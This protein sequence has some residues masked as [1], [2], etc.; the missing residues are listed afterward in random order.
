MRPGTTI[1]LLGAALVLV[2]GTVSASATPVTVSFFEVKGSNGYRVEVA[3][4][5]LGA[6]P[7]ETS[8]SVS[9]QGLSANYVTAGKPGRGFQADFGDLGHL[10]LAF[11]RRKRAVERP[12]KGCT[13]VSETGSFRGSFSFT[14]EGDYTSVDRSSVN[15]IV[16]DLPNG[17][18]GLPD[19]R[20]EL[21]S[22]PGLRTSSLG[23]KAR[24]PHGTVNFAASVTEG[25]AA[26]N[27]RP[28][29]TAS[30]HER[31]ETLTITRSALTSGIPESLS[32]GDGTR[33]STATVSP[34][35]PFTGSATYSRPNGAA[36]RWAGTLSV[37]LLGREPVALA[38][39]GFAARICLHQQLFATCKVSLPPA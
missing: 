27:D 7:V 4:S 39:E 35:A 26:A 8:V 25:P 1:A 36:A 2:F 22:L 11:H 5:K 3:S 33:S 9:R 29:F 10:R 20:P 31:L 32:L 12:E 17:F 34:P 15:G 18:C 14:G 6:K 23:A 28:H 16:L 37:S 13:I 21:P 38:G 30:L 24:V 19:E